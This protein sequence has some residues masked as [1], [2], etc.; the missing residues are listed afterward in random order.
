MITASHVLERARSALNRSTLSLLGEGGRD[1]ASPVPSTRLAVG[2][3]WPTLPAAQRAALEP[4]AREHGIDVHDP[5]LVMDACDCSG[6]V[7][8]ALGMPRHDPQSFPDSGGWIFTGSIWADAMGPATM[9]ERLPRAVPGALVVY[10]PHGGP[11][12]H[13]HVGIVVDV[14]GAGRAASVAHCSADNV[15]APPFDGIKITVPAQFDQSAKT[16]YARYRGM[17]MP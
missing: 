1:P 9:F 5:G 15:L 2:R 13:G 16:I 10:P 12:E 4:V 8:W 3:L 14:D 11:D 17:Q 6:Y 7:C